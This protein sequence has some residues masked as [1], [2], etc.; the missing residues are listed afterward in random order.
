M[1][2]GWLG[3]DWGNVPSWIASTLTG[4]SMLIAAMTY[5]RHVKEQA[6]QQWDRE[7]EQ[8]GRVSVWLESSRRALIRNGNEVGVTV[9]AYVDVAGAFA[10]SDRVACGP[11][12]TRELA[13][14]YE[15]ERLVT[16]VGSCPTPSVLI[17]D[18]SGRTWLRTT[19]GDLR[20][21]T[22]DERN[23]LDQRLAQAPIRMA[24]TSRGG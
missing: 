22:E 20:S 16:Q 5:R 18:S 8:A 19:R 14:P 12:E 11:G 1:S 21:P 17:V 13:L 15:Y 9:Q 3:L 6:R 7:R 24:L 2:A 4:S 23:A 10:V